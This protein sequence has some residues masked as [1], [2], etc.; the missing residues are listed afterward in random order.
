MWGML[1]YVGLYITV[2][3]VGVPNWLVVVGGAVGIVWA[4]GILVSEHHPV[5]ER[6]V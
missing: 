5:E 4:I 1:A 2:L 6:D 3:I